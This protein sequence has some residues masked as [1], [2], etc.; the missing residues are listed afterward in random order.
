MGEGLPG[1]FDLLKLFKLNHMMKY[2]KTLWGIIALVTLTTNGFSQNINWGSLQE[3]QKHLVRVHAGW[4]YGLVYGAGYGY[5]LKSNVPVLLNA[6]ASF[7]SGGR[8]LD[9][10]KT[11]VGGQVRLYAIK[12]VHFSASVHAI[13]RRYENPLVRLQNIGSEM[14]VAIGLYKTKWYVAGEF[15]FDKAVV[16]H[17]THSELFRE[18]VYPE[19]QDGWYKP[20]TG[21]NFMYGI[22][23]GYS[24][25]RSDI[26]L[27]IGRVVTQDFKS[28]PMIP[29]YLQVGYVYRINGKR[30]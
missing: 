25:K 10:F 24:M 22:Q 2:T 15:G 18:I 13:Y 9:D 19:V 17:F 29:Y 23:A 6:S 11:K 12:N 21:G 5:R 7:P 26:V 16:T 1:C 8:L 28:S 14:T 4:D 20:A 27:N 30:K 3:E